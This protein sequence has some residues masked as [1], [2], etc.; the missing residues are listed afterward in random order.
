MAYA[1]VDINNRIVEWSDDKL[2]G[3]DVEFS[4]GDYIHMNERNGVND[5]VIRDGEAVFEP[6]K[7]SIE[8]AKRR[9][10]DPYQ[11]SNDLTDAIIELGEIASEQKV[12]NEEIMDAIIELAGEFSKLKEGVGKWLNFMQS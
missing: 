1:R 6:T 12:A 5:F 11:T 4:N 9:E 10:F 2:D 3:L 8:Q 7:E